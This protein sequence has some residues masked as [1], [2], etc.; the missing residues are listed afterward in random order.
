MVLNFD[1]F[2]RGLAALKSEQL[3]EKLA[4]KRVSEAMAVDKYQ[5]D[6]SSYCNKFCQQ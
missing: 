3:E 5:G 1:R 2:L 6:S 4:H